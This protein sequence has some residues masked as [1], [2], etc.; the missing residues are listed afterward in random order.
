MWSM[1]QSNLVANSASVGPST[2]SLHMLASRADCRCSA[3]L[4]H[5]TRPTQTK[6]AREK[7][8]PNVL[9]IER[10]NQ[11]L[12]EEIEKGEFKGFY[13]WGHLS[14]APLALAVYRT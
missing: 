5:L 8:C 4:F 3:P 11:A 2:P 13:V 1:V 12:F 6:C 14:K 7:N 10:E 9:E